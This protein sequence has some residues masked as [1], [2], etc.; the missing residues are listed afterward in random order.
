MAIWIGATTDFVA[1]FK[2]DM[3]WNTIHCRAR[4]ED[5]GAFMSVVQIRYL[6]YGLPVF[7]MP[8]VVEQPWPGY[9]RVPGGSGS[10]CER[11]DS[12]SVS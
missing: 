5:M 3:I 7:S 9:A 2:R 4:R 6:R 11:I 12:I 8:M 10:S 1:F